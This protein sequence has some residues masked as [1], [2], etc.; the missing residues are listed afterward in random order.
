MIKI[1]NYLK[2][3]GQGIVEYALLLSFI[4]GLA[5]MLNGAG[6]SSAV[7]DVFEDVSN[8]LSFANSSDFDIAKALKAMEKDK[9]KFNKNNA[10]WGRGMIRSSWNFSN[11]GL[12]QETIDSMNA[13]ASELG[14]ADWMF[15]HEDGTRDP[16]K[17]FDNVKGYG[18][19]WTTE[20]LSSLDLNDQNKAADGYSDESVLSYYYNPNTQTYSVIAN[21][22][23]VKQKDLSGTTEEK[24]ALSALQ[25]FNKPIVDSELTVYTVGTAKTYAEAQR[26]YNEAKAANGGSAVI[27]NGN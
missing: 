21:R 24:R 10:S 4:V 11:C 2:Q 13:I 12:D 8:V 1:T 16:G 15:C 23:W 3:K 5:M 20:S 25:D 14:A 22:V 17:A 27:R 26:I 9:S 6:L 18:L 19:Y 7:K